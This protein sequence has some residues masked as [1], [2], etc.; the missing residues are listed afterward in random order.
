MKKKPHLPNPPMSIE[1]HQFLK[2]LGISGLSPGQERLLEHR[3]TALADQARLAARAD[4]L[5]ALEWFDLEPGRR[6]RDNP[7]GPTGSDG[8][9]D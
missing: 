9:A 7:S 4:E 8:E 3:Q 6:G 5:M 2:E 1:D